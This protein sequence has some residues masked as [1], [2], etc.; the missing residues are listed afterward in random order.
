MP[1]IIKGIIPHHLIIMLI[2]IF[3]AFALR[4]SLWEFESIDYLS[5]TSQWYDF[6]VANG[7]FRALKH[8]FANYTPLY[9][10]MIT[11][12]TYTLSW[13]PK[14]LALKLISITFDFLC[15]FFIF[16]I[17]RLSYPTGLRPMLACLLPLFAP[18]IVLNSALWGQADIIYTTALVATLYFLAT[19][20]EIAAW[21][22]F[23]LA[24][25]FKLQAVFFAPVLLILLLKRYLAWRY[26]LL[27]PLVYLL[28][29]IP[30]W[31]IGR[32]LPDLLL[33]YAQQ[34]DY[35]Q[36]LTMNAPN[37]YQWFPNDFYDILYPAGMIWAISIMFLFILLIH[38]SRRP[39][40]APFLIE[41]ATLSVLIAPY[42]LPKMHERY[43]FAA[44]IFS[45][46]FALYF[47]RYF[48][49]PLLIILTSFFSYLPFLFNHEVIPLSYLALVPLLTIIILLHHLLRSK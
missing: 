47:P 49:I 27:V 44:D 5:F 46:L 6:I 36:A 25:A 45:I 24:F 23:G 17:V 11:F 3:L 38:H 41:I 9:L 22:A 30:A 15:A 13:L 1:N 18:T 42:V 29:I 48:F 20:R 10:Y 39:L 16:K 43:F 12:A 31:L 40:T 2:G 7:G 8:S 21:V 35:Y 4:L 28:T 34:A 33:I 26:C 32:P 37:M 19:K 14:V